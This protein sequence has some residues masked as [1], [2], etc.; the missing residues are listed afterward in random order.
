MVL[1][2]DSKHIAFVHTN[3]A[4]DPNPPTINILDRATGAKRTLTTGTYPVWASSDGTRL[5]FVERCRIWVIPAKGGKRTALTARPRAGTC[6]SD[7]A[8]SPDGRWIAAT[9]NDGFSPPKGGLSFIP[10][11]ARS[12]GKPIPTVAHLGVQGPLA[13][14]LQ[15][16]FFYPTPN[17]PTPSGDLTLVGAVVGWIVP[18]DAVAPGSPKSPQTRSSRRTPTGAAPRRTTAGSLPRWAVSSAHHDRYTVLSGCRCVDETRRDALGLDP[19]VPKNVA[20]T[21]QAPTAGGAN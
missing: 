17:G 7:Q 6:A 5:G 2:A 13:T 14:G 18:T 9:T 3:G 16:L 10:L 8:W 15:R 20:R 1:V 21:R 12:D 19:L 11:V 4:D